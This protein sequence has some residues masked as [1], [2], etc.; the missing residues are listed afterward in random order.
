MSDSTHLDV[1]WVGQVGQIWSQWWDGAPGMNWTDHAPFAIATQFP[2]PAQA[3]SA[4]AAVSRA[5]AR[6]LPLSITLRAVQDQGRFIEVAGVG[7]TPNQT[8]TLDYVISTGGGPETHQ[9]G[10]HT[11]TSDGTGSFIDRI[12]VT[13]GGNITEASVKA[14]D[15]ASQAT[16]EA[17]IP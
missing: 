16:A 10:E 6:A 14:A 13:L 17:T 8:V 4:I 12:R 7:F 9:T 11:L 5:P 1:F 3:N 15:V 2:V